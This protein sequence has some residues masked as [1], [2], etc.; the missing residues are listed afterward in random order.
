MNWPSIGDKNSQYNHRIQEIRI[1]ST[2][3]I[4][5]YCV[6]HLP[7]KDSEPRCSFSNSETMNESTRSREEMEMS[8]V[9]VTKTL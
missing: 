6:V 8:T 3:S 4:L 2:L 7:N 1:I 9:F 5:I